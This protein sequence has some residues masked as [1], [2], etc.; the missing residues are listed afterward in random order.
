MFFI[1]GKFKAKEDEAEAEEKA[2]AKENENG[3]IGWKTFIK[4]TGY[5]KYND[6]RDFSVWKKAYELVLTIYKL[7][8]SYHS[9]E[10]YGITSDMRR[11]ANSITSNVA[12]GYGRYEGKDKS[13]FYKIARGSATELQS[14]VLV[15]YGLG[16]I[17][18]IKERDDAFDR[19]AEIINEL[20]NLIKTVESRKSNK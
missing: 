4:D 3:F 14:Q 13:R 2:E 20:N 11:S 12:E 9:D 15:S 1:P 10:R 18:E 17:K 7:T 19:I 16:Y 5:M 8:E 6:F